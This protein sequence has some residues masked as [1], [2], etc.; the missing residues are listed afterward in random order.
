[1]E[2]VLVQE[3]VQVILLHNQAQAILA[4]LVQALL[5]AYQ[6]AAILVKLDLDKLVLPIHNKVQI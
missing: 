5:Q 1:M 3:L 4:N 6:Q 2:L